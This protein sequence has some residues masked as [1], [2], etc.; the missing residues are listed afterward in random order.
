MEE[1][2]KKVLGNCLVGQS[3]GPTVAINASLCGVINRVIETNAYN[4]IYGMINGIEGLLQN[5]VLN[6]SELFAAE[7]ERK[8]L[9]TTPAMY[10]GSCRY[11]LPSISESPDTYTQIFDILKELDIQTFFYIGGNDSMDTVLQLSIFAKEHNYPVQVIGIPKTI[12]N[13]LPITDHTPG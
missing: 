1:I 4:T 6:L 2:M 3:G 7:G 10:L 9:A 11:K 13:D 12:D 8:K 5:K